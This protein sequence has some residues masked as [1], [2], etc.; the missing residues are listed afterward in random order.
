MIPYFAH[1]I[2]HVLDTEDTSIWNRAKAQ[3]IVPVTGYGQTN[4]WEDLAEFSRCFLQARADEAR[5]KP[6]EM[7]HPARTKAFKALLYT[8]DNEFYAEYKDEYE[9]VMNQT[10]DYDKS[11][12]VKLS[13]DGKY[14]TDKNG[15]LVLTE[16]YEEATKNWQTWEA[17]SAKAGSTKFKNKATGRMLTLTN[18]VLTLGEGTSMG[19]KSAD[20]GY[21]MIE[22]A[23]GFALGKDMKVTMDKGAIWKIEEVGTIPFTGDFAIKLQVTGKYLAYNEEDGLHFEDK[24]FAWSINPVDEGYYI[25]RDK[26]TGKAFDINGGSKAEGAKALIWQVTGGQNQHFKFVSDEYGAYTLELRHSG[27]NLTSTEEG[28]FQSSGDMGYM[29]WNLIRV[30]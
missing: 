28:F 14:L 25:I 30:N 6:L 2:G 27:L 13:L 21:M 20:D 10:G 24:P 8:K 18:H 29:K 5:L 16:K 9:E 19:L 11:V 1:E 12:Q 22:T 7:T 3:D 15:E 26:A 23:T 17:L 4:R